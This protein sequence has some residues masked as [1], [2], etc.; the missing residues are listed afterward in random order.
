MTMP[1]FITKSLSLF[2]FLVAVAGAIG[3]IPAKAQQFI[4]M[5]KEASVSRMYGAIHFRSDCDAGL[6]T[7]NKVG[8][9]AIARGHTDGAE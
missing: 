2:V 5:A 1:H 7:G 4:D 8:S 9:Y 6:T 3:I